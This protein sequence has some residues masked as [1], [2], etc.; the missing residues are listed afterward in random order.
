[1]AGGDLYS[2][3]WVLWPPLIRLYLLRYLRERL[4]SRKTCDALL[5]DAP[6]LARYAWSEIG[7]SSLELRVG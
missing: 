1:M 7:L 4:M 2:L 3:V 6:T 5:G